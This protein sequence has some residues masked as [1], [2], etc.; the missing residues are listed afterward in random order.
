[1]VLPLPTLLTHSL[2]GL[3]SVSV[4]QFVEVLHVR[5]NEKRQNNHSSETWI[6]NILKR[7]IHML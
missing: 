5:K 2:T 7:N 6:Y 3:T 4:S 1:M